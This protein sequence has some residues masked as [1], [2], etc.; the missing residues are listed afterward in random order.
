M[1][2]GDMTMK[3]KTCNRNCFKCKYDEEKMKLEL[4]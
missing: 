3:G 2:N 1:T 4:L